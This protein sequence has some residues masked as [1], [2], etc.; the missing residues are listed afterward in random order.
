M[1]NRLRGDAGTGGA[2]VGTGTAILALG[3]VNDVETVTFRDGVLRAFG[4]AG[5]A[6]YA[7]S[8][9]LI[10]HFYNPFVLG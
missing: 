2:D 8:S 7:I 1:H 3:G 6:G 9:D 5:A 4:F 10:S